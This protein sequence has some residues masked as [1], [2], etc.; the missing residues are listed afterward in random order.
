MKRLSHIDRQSR[1]INNNIKVI[2]RMVYAFRDKSY[3]YWTITTSLQISD[4][5]DS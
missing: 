4:E 5:P 2:K 1:W 3:M